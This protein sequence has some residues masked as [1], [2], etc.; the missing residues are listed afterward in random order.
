MLNRISKATRVVAFRAQPADRRVFLNYALIARMVIVAA[1]GV[2]A[3]TLLNDIVPSLAVGGT[4]DA[5]ALIVD[6]LRAQVQISMK[7]V[8]I[9]RD[10]FAFVWG[11]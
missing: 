5:T 11:V 7:L 3:V 2:L 6:L 8:S 9:G 10:V 1:L 4:G